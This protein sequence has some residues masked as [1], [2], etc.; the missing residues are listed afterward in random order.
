MKY[1]NYKTYN[2]NKFFKKISFKIYNFLKFV[3]YI[4]F[5]QFSPKKTYKYLID[6]Q[7]EFLKIF[8]QKIY[9]YYKASVIY[10]IGTTVALILISLIIPF[11]YSYDK[12]NIE[13]LICEDFKV[14]C[15]IK[16]KIYYN[17]I[18]TPRLVIKNLQLQSLSD[19]KYTFG[20]IE[21]TEIALPIKELYKKS[22]KDIR[23]VKLVK[24]KLFIEYKKIDEYKNLFVN[25]KNNNVIIFKKSDIDFFDGSKYITSINKFDAKYKY[26]KNFDELTLKGIFLGDDLNINFE[27]SL[28]EEKNLLV[29]LKALNFLSKISFNKSK[30]ENIIIGKA[31]IK[32]D[33]NKIT[34]I[35]N[36]KNNEIIIKKANLRSSFSDGKVVGKIKFKPFFD[37][38]LN[39]DLNNLN[40]YILSKKINELD[41]ERKRKLFSINNKIN[42]KLDL[43][44]SKMFSKKTL[45]NSF[46]SQIQ[47]I[48]GNILINRLL[49]GMGKLGAADL[50]GIIKNEKNFTNL[51]FSSNVFIDN[52]KRFFSK[53][54]VYNKEKNPFDLFISG[55]LDLTNFKMRLFEL[56]SKIKFSNEDITYIENEFN[57]LLLAEGYKSLFDFSN[58]KKFIRLVSGQEK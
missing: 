14:K 24:A 11:F 46:E 29:K 28:N 9:K 17:F 45:I 48:N 35:F 12:S 33:K 50:N 31:L 37:F 44:T 49:L 30:K 6:L 43:S 22:K 4:K 23:N 16:G 36:Y 51:K 2:L 19:N 10:L 53:F 54:G 58:F 8:K 18:P 7:Y 27:S 47:F 38:D 20:K 34:S 25:K 39:I 15:N 26:K 55:N 5:K 13:S 52:S 56:S 57:D 40:F 3:K 42:G 1:F 21:R 41:D 32:K